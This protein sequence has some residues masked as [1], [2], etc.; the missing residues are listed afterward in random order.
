MTSY[1]RSLAGHKDPL[2]RLLLKRGKWFEGRA[3]S[4][5]HATTD[6]WRKAVRPKPKECYYNAQLFCMEHREGRYFEGYALAGDRFVV[7]H[8]WV[9]IPD[10]QLID[11]TWE[12][13][14]RKLRRDGV[15]SDT[16]QALYLGAEVPTPAFCEVICRTGVS[17]PVLAGLAA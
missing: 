14:D 12:A 3:D 4:H 6:G 8:A 9:V 1:L 13:M 11:F 7:P 5:D 10:G 2:A 15:P 16:A 17:G